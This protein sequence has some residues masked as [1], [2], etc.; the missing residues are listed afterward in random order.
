VTRSVPV[1]R[2][3]RLQQI[4]SHS[5]RLASAAGARNGAVLSAATDPGDDGTTSAELWL[6]GVVGGY[7]WGFNDKTVADQLRGL[8]VDQITVRLNSPGGDSIQGIAIGNLLRNHKAAVTVVVDG[9]AAS[10]A[11]I[12]AIAGDEV[13]MSPGSQL[14]IHDPWF[15]TMGNAKELRQDADFLDKQGANM[16][17]VYA[18][19]AGG[20]P[21]SWRAAMTADPDG[22]WYSADEAVTA[23]LADRVGTVVAISAAPE[24]PPVDLDDEDDEMAA[25]A[26]WD[27]E[28]LITPAARAAWN[29]RAEAGPKPPSPTGPGSV[30]PTQEGESAVAFSDEQLTAMRQQLGLAETRTRRPS[31]PPRRGP[32]RAG[33]GPGLGRPRCPDHRR[34]SRGRRRH[35]RRRARPAAGR[36]HRR[37][38]GGGASADHRPRR[39]HRGCVPRRQDH[40]QHPGQLDRVLGQ[41]PRPAPRPCSTRS[42]PGLIPVELGH[43]SEPGAPGEGLGIRR[44]RAGRLRRLPRP[45]QGGPPWVT[46]SPSSPAAPSPAP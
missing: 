41:E 10:A 9:L 31:W 20:T 1:A 7:W 25:R 11:S 15:F 23:K 36:R 12:I 2:V 5:S 28:V 43:E 38:R 39:R 17:G 46:T 16:A 33:R 32:C 42:R 29:V 22:T 8:N 18:L 21:E 37:R 44:R 3:Q 19:E 45:E 14:M 40:R 27:L 6:Y 26:A 24:P 35:R 30:T 4:H 34:D 13:V